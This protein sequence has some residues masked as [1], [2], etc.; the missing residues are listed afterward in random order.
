MRGRPICWSTWRARP[1]P[2][3]G[4]A[5]DEILPLPRLWRPP[6]APASLAGFLNL[7]GE[8]V[9]V[10]DLAAL[11]G[12]SAP[13]GRGLYRHLVVCAAP[14]IALMVERVTDLVTVPPDAVRP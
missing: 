12:L 5:A 7:A 8:A 14:R 10:L 9:A 13:A 3:G 4:A 6:G 1:A 11:L 2:C